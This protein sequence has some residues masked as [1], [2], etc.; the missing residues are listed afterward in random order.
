MDRR[1]LFA[2]L[3]VVGTVISGTATVLSLNHVSKNKRNRR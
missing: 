3:R 2:L 1:V